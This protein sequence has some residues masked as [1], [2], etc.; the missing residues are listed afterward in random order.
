MD[1]AEAI[2]LSRTKWIK[3]AAV[4]ESMT[5]NDQRDAFRELVLEHYDREHLALRKYVLYLGV[6]VETAS[7]VVQESFLKLHEHVR[8][9]GDRTNLR[10]WLYRVAH[11]LTR[12][13]QAAPD[14]RRMD[15]L[16]NLTGPAEPVAGVFTPEQA[17]LG[18]ERDAALQRAM[19]ELSSPQ[20]E[21]LA[22]RAQGFKYREM[23]EVLGLSVS[24]VAENVQ[25]GLERLRKV[26]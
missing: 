18:K 1:P 24:T 23:T 4:R 11:N 12:N 6:D 10:A 26:L 21:C 16:S 7:D 5:A 15:A 25:R 13:K 20:R 8:R 3:S 2:A 14:S 9:G 17:L 22:L 19:R